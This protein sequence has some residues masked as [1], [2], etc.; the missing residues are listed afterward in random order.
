[1][2]ERRVSLHSIKEVDNDVLC[3]YKP[4]KTMLEVQLFTKGAIQ[5]FVE[6][7]VEVKVS[8]NTALNDIRRTAI[9]NVRAACVRNKTNLRTRTIRQ[10]NTACRPVCPF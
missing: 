5:T 7:G 6:D 9:S 2:S 1:M 8:V 4:S 10:H 3:G